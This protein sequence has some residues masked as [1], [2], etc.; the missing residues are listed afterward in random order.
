M[1]KGYNKS[2]DSAAKRL[3]L[4]SCYKI[5]ATLD[6]GGYFFASES[7]LHTTIKM[8]VSITKY[9]I[10][11]AYFLAVR[12]G[13]VANRPLMNPCKHILLFMITPFFRISTT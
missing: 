6:R 9:S 5:T 7:I 4:H 3:A 1:H 10:G 2:R 12:N 11:I 13:K 8:T